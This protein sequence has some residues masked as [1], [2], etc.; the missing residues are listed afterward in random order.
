MYG[1]A[2]RGVCACV[3]V[4]VCVCVC[5]CVRACV[6]AR[7]CVYTCRPRNIACCS[8]V[9]V[10]CIVI[11]FSKMSAFQAVWLMIAPLAPILWIRAG[12]QG[13]GPL[14]L[15]LQTNMSILCTRGYQKVRSSCF[16]CRRMPVGAIFTSASEMYFTFRPLGMC[17]R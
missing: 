9:V 8:L 2:M 11:A 5:A 16:K 14:M 4:C 15:A 1:V 10:L 17:V 13:R 3:C 7:V 6:R 12:V